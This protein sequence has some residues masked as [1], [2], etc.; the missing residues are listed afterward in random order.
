MA[1]EVDGMTKSSEALTVSSFLSAT[2]SIN[3]RTLWSAL[4]PVVNTNQLLLLPE[5]FRTPT[6]PERHRK[7]GDC[8]IGKDSSYTYITLK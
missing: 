7:T 2:L 8:V 4:C 1:K 6:I 3:N 5:R